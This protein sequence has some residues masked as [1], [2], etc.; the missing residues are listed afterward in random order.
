MLLRWK[1][2]LAE[3]KHIDLFYYEHEVE[4]VIVSTQQSSNWNVGYITNV[5]YEWKQFI[6]KIVQK[7]Q[8]KIVFTLK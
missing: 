4:G 1:N 5:K 2:Y 7:V 8:Q 6:I 3:K